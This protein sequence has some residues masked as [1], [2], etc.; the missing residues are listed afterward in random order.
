MKISEHGVT[1]PTAHEFDSVV[2]TLAHRRA[3]APAARRDLAEM[4]SLV[5]PMDGPNTT[6]AFLRMR[7]MSVGLTQCQVPSL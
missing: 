6:T 2:S 3:M 7:V 4:S 5:K 1:A